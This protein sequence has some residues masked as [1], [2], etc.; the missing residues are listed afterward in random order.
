[1]E[2]YTEINSYLKSTGVGYK[3][4]EKKILIG[5]IFTF[6]IELKVDV[7]RKKVSI[8][9]YYLQ[10][11]FGRFFKPKIVS[12][13]QGIFKDLKDIFIEKGFEVLEVSRN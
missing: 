8:S 12:K 11:L 1:M 7:E 13:A 10:S 2:N 4:G 6:Y 3:I 5:N 9:F